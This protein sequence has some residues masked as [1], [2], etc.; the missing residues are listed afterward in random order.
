MVKEMGFVNRTI[1][2]IQLKGSGKSFHDREIDITTVSEDGCEEKHRYFL[3]GGIDFLMDE[4][5]ETRVFYLRIG[6]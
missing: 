1:D 2:V 6:G 3:T 4:R 5:S